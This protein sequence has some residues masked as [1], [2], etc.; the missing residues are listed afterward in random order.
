M[1][2]VTF[3]PAQKAVAV[4]QA[5]TVIKIKKKGVSRRYRSQGQLEEAL[6]RSAKSLRNAMRKGLKSYSV[7]REESMERKN[8]LIKDYPKNASKGLRRFSSSAVQIPMAFMERVWDI[9]AARRARRRLNIFPVRL[10]FF[11]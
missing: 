10:P 4:P 7:A 1:P 3:V 11:R 2:K 9:K 8:G 6:F 5:G